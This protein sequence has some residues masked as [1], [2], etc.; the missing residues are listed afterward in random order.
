MLC[1]ALIML[2]WDCSWICGNFDSFLI[3][4]S[5]WNSGV[6]ESC[7]LVSVLVEAGVWIDLGG[8]FN[9]FF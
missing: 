6:I 4:L 3:L 1:F 5:S 9:E 2:A 7:E 8:L